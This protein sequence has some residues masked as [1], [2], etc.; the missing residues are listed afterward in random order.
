[1]ATLVVCLHAILRTPDDVESPYG[2]LLSS[3]E[4]RRV[5]DL[6]LV[7]FLQVN[8]SLNF[9]FFSILSSI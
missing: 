1:M 5:I 8:R 2:A 6:D 7:V 3:V 4:N 9:K